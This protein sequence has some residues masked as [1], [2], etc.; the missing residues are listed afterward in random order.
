LAIHEKAFLLYFLL[1]KDGLYLQFILNL[2]LEKKQVSMK[3]IKEIFQDFII[4]KLE[5]SIYSV[6][7]S[8]KIK[9]DIFLRIKRIRNWE[10]PKRYLEHIIEPRV[11]WLLDLGL[12][13]KN[14]F[15]KNS[16][17]LSEEGLLFLQEINTSFDINK[18][19]FN[20]IQKVYSHNTAVS[21]ENNDFGLISNYLEKSFILFKTTAPNRVTASQAILYTCYMMLFKEKKVVNFSTIQGYLSSKENTSFIYE[22]Y[23][24]EQDGSIRRKK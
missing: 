12:L 9:K 1:E 2:I 19:F 11:N 13:C 8:N 20:L 17:V 3:N 18:N 5:D 10:N 22:W 6:E 21:L 4:N 15:K 23:K 16:L 14:D 24:T 7:I